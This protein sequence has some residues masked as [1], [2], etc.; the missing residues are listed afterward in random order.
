LTTIVF[1]D[2]EASTALLD[3][4]G[5]VIGMASLSRQLGQVRER[6]EAYGGNLVKSTGDGYLLTF[7]SPRQA[8]SFALAS[9]RVLAGS[10]P[11]V[12]VGINTGEVVTDGPDPLGAAV[13]AAARIA[14]R[15]D[16]EVLVSDVVRQLVGTVPAV[17]FLDRGRC[18]LRGFSERWHLWAAED[19]TNEQ[20]TTATIGRIAELARV[21]D[22]VSSTAAGVGRVPTTLRL[23][24]PTMK[25]SRS[26]A[27]RCGKN[28]TSRTHAAAAR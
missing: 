25:C 4:V 23:S 20:H 14:G 26:R 15:A 28:G 2:V 21:A 18:R 24:S 12:R 7:S 19:S 16:G 1:V 6:V 3:R 22:L 10:L 27:G 5:D 11:R 9:Q 13:N 17:R 8:L